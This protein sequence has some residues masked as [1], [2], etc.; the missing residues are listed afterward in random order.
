MAKRK[1]EAVSRGAVELDLMAEWRGV[2]TDLSVCRALGVR[3]RKLV[4]E[5]KLA[6]CVRGVDWDIAN[7]EVGMMG[8]WCERNGLEL[9]DLE[10]AGVSGRVTFEVCARVSNLSVVLAK[11]LDTGVIEPVRVGD[12]R[13]WRLGMVFEAKRGYG[14]WEIDGACLNGKGY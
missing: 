13:A 10:A 12:A 4:E 8:A 3:R 7:G 1:F 11:R 14:G 9:E 2:Y 6:G 5:R